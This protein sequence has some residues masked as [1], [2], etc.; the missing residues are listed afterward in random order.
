MENEN[1]EMEKLE[2]E[3]LERSSRK[4]VWRMRRMFGKARVSCAKGNFGMHH[5]LDPAVNFGP[6]E[7][8]PHLSL[9]RTGRSVPS[10]RT[11]GG[12]RG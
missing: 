6:E 4:T 8:V 10:C 1:L 3:S 12:G 5:T 9:R 2:N 7:E 11:P